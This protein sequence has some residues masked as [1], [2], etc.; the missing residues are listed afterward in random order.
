MVAAPGPQA[1][2]LWGGA[3]LTSGSLHSVSRWRAVR[4][5]VWRAVRGS[6]AGWQRLSWRAERGAWTLS[7]PGRARGLPTAAQ[8]G[9][10][11]HGTPDGLLTG[12][13]SSTSV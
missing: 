10:T 4:R 12:A 8:A 6:G 1:P 11:H 13:F 9:T 5:A 7:Q 3:V 2:P